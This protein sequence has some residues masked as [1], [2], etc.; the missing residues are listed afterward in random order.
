MSCFISNL[1][2][3]NFE[4]ITF[5]AHLID[6]KCSWRICEKVDASSRVTRR[7]DDSIKTRKS[8]ILTSVSILFCDSPCFS[9]DNLLIAMFDFFIAGTN[10]TTL[11][12]DCIFWH[13]T[14]HQDVQRKLHKEIDRVIGFSRFPDLEDKPKYVVQINLLLRANK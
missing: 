7:A 12:L 11:M 9:D 1:L 10:D 4:R 5:R 2:C 3:A 8:D 6:R 13:V 14:K